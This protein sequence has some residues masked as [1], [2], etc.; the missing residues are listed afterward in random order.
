M[1]ISFKDAQ[2]HNAAVLKRPA[3]AAPAGH[4][5]KKPSAAVSSNRPHSGQVPK[6]DMNDIFDELRATFPG[7]RRTS[8]ITRGAFVTKAYK[9]A[10]KR[11]SKAGMGILDTN[12]FAKT[13]HLRAADLWAQLT[14][15]NRE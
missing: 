13:N 6:P 9:R 10:E 8:S 2:P 7:N 15:P 3:G 14:N 1:F 5:A 11:A 4:I 12:L